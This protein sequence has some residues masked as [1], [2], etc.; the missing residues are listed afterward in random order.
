MPRNHRSRSAKYGD[1][2]ADL[3]FARVMDKLVEHYGIVLGEST[4]RHITQGHAHKM[5]E[6]SANAIP[7]WPCCAFRGT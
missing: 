5:F 7:S 6:A 4:I 3:P 2:G 1:F